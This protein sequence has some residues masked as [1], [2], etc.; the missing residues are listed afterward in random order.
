MNIQQEQQVQQPQQVPQWLSPEQPLS[1]P[2]SPVRKGFF[3][4][5]I[6]LIP[7]WAIILTLVAIVAIGAS[8]SWDLISSP[9]AAITSN[10][11]SVPTV[12]GTPV[13]RFKATH[14]F[15]GYGVERTDVFHV[16][17]DWKIV[18][19]CDPSS[20]FGQQYN[21]VVSV[22][23]S[24]GRTIDF[25]AVNAMCTPGHT[26]DVKEEHQGGD[27]YLDIT[28]EGSWDIQVQELE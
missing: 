3:R 27:I 12:T 26:T 10:R 9:A 2:A 17:N 6:G 22:N 16:A 15:M 24:D 20:F 21:L 1:F 25:A 14:T 8:V 18:W 4:G 23:H 19:S 13:P 11:K 5:K 28:S 7:F